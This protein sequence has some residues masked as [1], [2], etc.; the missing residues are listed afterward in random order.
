MPDAERQNR[1]KIV[2]LYNENPAWPDSDKLWTAQMVER[3]A[4]SLVEKGFEYQPLKIFD[5]LAALD[6]FSPKEWLV[7]NWAEELGGK[8]WTD[9]VIA[10]QLGARG[11]AYTGSQT[12]TLSRS[13]DRL[14]V[15]QRLIAANVPTLTARLFTDSR[16]ASE[17]RT[18]P[19]IVKGANQHGSFGIDHDTVVHT[20]EQLAH[21]IDYMREIYNDDSLVEQFLDSREF[22]VAVFGNGRPQALPPAE[23]DYSAF[24][25]MQDRLYTYTWKYD[26]TSWGYHAIQI[27]APSPADQPELQARLQT[28]AVAAYKALGVTDYGRVD[29]RML[30]ED[31]QVLD[32]NANPDLDA[33]SALMAS[34]RAVGLTYADI[35][36]RIINNAATRM[37]Q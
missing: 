22:H 23:Y 1:P 29:L 35:V 26:D 18:F 21:R 8:A 37:V 32:V 5:S 31:P 28:V 10:A 19:A 24:T 11:F 36:E 25:D 3:L 15:K 20:P 12:E 30:G 16:A 17:W 4:Q 2:I 9:S 33:T 13:C 34:A 27:I 6:Q 14:W 7:W